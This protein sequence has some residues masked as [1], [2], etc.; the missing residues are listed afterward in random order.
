VILT[1]SPVPRAP[2]A[3][4]H[5]YL[6]DTTYADAPARVLLHASGPA[7]P[8]GDGTL[9]VQVEPPPIP[10]NVTCT[11]RVHLDLDGDGAISSGD[12]IT[13]RSYRLA[14]SVELQLD[15]VA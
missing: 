9:V 5:I 15:Q 3:L 1:I 13:T 7:A 6:E 10:E 14:S 8:R 11:V 12:Y 4:L 2:E